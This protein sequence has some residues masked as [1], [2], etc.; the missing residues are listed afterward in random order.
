[1]RSVV[2]GSNR[3]ITPSRSVMATRKSLVLAIVAAAFSSACA[4]IPYGPGISVMPADGKSLADF[5]A[6][7]IT[8]RRFAERQTG[9]MTPTNA[10]TSSAA[11][12]AVVGTALGAAAGAAFDGG[13][14]AAIGAG[15]G[16]LAGSML[17]AGIGNASAGEVQYRYD[18]AYAQC[19]AAQGNRVP[20]PEP[21]VA[22][23]PQPEPYY[24]PPA[25]EYVVERYVYEQPVYVE[26]Y[27]PYGHGHYHHHRRC[28]HHHGYWY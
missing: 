19:M 20:H 7:T 4:T 6:D 21:A 14:G 18:N 25:R 27:Y 23:A 3:V 9:G 24:P 16:L 22:A 10:A 2:L 11:Q 26:P 17:G 1:M 15:T 28:H 13:E 5:E 8:C 12:S